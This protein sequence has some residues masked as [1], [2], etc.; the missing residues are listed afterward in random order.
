M[1]PIAILSVIAVYLTIERYL[2]I[3]KSGDF[4]LPIYGKNKRYGG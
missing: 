3:K 4:R 1:I 2:T